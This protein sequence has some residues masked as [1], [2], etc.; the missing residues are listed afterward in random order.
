MD[1][2]KMQEETGAEHRDVRTA[3]EA[4]DMLPEVE[5]LWNTRIR[6]DLIYQQRLQLCTECWAFF[7]YGDAENTHPKESTV[8]AQKF[9]LMHKVT[10][11][12]SLLQLFLTH[13]KFDASQ[14]EM[15]TSLPNN[16]RRPRFSP[17]HLSRPCETSSLLRDPEVRWCKD[18]ILELEKELARTSTMV[19]GVTNEAKELR[20]VNEDL[21][22]ALQQHWT[23][24]Q[25]FKRAAASYANHILTLCQGESDKQTVNIKRN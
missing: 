2:R 24:S 1:G 20:K 4:L 7:E 18:R 17:C 16:W 11:P 12:S 23:A 8:T 15:N 25:K 10:S 5:E 19:S 21:L 6:A 3:Q 22:Q 14:M 13:E 9:L